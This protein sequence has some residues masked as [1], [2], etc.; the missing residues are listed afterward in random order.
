MT[1]RNNRH[2]VRPPEVEGGTPVFLEN[3]FV[4]FYRKTFLLFQLKFYCP[5]IC[6]KV[7][8]IGYKAP[9]YTR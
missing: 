5:F 1:E 4:V 6:S 7:T 8:V 3:S 9:K 2:D